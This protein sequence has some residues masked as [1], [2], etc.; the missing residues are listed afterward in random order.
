MLHPSL[1]AARWTST[2]GQPRPGFSRSGPAAR[3]GSA[4]EPSSSARCLRPRPQPPSGP[5]W[6]NPCQVR[7]RPVCRSPRGS[8]R[9]AVSC[10][11]KL[12]AAAARWA[13][14]RPRRARRG[15]SAAP[16]PN[17]G[18][19]PWPRPPRPRRRPPSRRRPST[20]SHPLPLAAS[21]AHRQEASLP[22]SAMWETAGPTLRAWADT[23]RLQARPFPSRPRGCPW[24]R[25]GPHSCCKTHTAQRPP[26]PLP[27]R[28]R[29]G[30]TFAR[31]RR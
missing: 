10:P 15:A 19:P 11:W 29:F 4:E 7:R 26:R 22:R 1:R 6:P 8:I 9:P 20:R 24:P 17:R 12:L 31:A 21:C 13:G 25:R 18:F 2:L 27:R 14:R 28:I 30:K 16:P 3:T 5:L 23:A